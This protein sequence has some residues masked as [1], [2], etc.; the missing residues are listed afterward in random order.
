M[1]GG[2]MFANK[3]ME[4]VENEDFVEYKSRTKQLEGMR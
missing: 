4:S 1:S 2:R 3:E